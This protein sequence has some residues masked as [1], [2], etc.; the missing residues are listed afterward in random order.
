MIVVDRAHAHRVEA[1]AARSARA[2]LG[3]ALAILVDGH[4]RRAVVGVREVADRDEHLGLGGGELREEIALELGAGIEIGADRDPDGA[5]IVIGAARCARC[6]DP[7]RVPPLD[8]QRHL[9]RRARLEIGRHR[10]PRGP[11]RRDP[12]RV[13]STVLRESRTSTATARERLDH[14]AIENA[15]EAGSNTADA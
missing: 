2:Q 1:R 11:R 8:E 14:T 3:V 7:S 10:R 9:V 13:A 6:V 12:T 4:R 15:S 5:V